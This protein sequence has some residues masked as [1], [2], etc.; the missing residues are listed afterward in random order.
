MIGDKRMEEP[1][2]ESETMDILEHFQI[3]HDP[4]D[5]TFN[6]I[7]ALQLV[8]LN[9]EAYEKMC[10]SLEARPIDEW[11]EDYGD[12]L[13]WKFPI[14]EPPYCGSPLDCDF[15]EDYYTHFTRLIIPI[16]NNEVYEKMHK[17]KKKKVICTACNGSGHYDNDGSPKCGC[18]NGKGYEY[19]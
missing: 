7:N 3:L 6:M 10:K 4:K 12:C 18:C 11:G 2:T 19:K 5:Y 1:K 9:N 16:N 15:T 8:E 13:F 17:P 14:E